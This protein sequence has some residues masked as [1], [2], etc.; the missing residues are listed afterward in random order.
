MDPGGGAGEY[1]WVTELAV[2][3]EELLPEVCR[4]LGIDAE[5]PA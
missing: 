2:P 5:V 4:R 3:A 1:P